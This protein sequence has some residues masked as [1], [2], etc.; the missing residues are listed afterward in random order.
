LIRA[1]KRSNHEDRF[2]QMSLQFHQQIRKGFLEIA[3]SH[4]ERCVVVN[5]EEEEY[6][7]RD[8]IIKVIESHLF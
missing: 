4:P 7:I 3:K 1:H 6:Q 2:E 8:T 5:A